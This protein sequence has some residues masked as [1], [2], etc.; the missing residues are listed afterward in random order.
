MH[1]AC[2]PAASA[3]GLPGAQLGSIF[4]Q[5]SSAA[6]QGTHAAAASSSSS[7]SSGDGGGVSA[8]RVMRVPSADRL[9]KWGGQDGCGVNPAAAAVNVHVAHLQVRRADCEWRAAAAGR[10]QWRGDP[11]G[12]SRGLSSGSTAAEPAMSEPAWQRLGGVVPKL[13]VVL[14]LQRPSKPSRPSFWSLRRLKRTMD[15]DRTVGD[16]PAVSEQG[17]RAASSLPRCLTY[18]K[19][20]LQASQRIA[21]G[22]SCQMPP[23]PPGMEPPRQ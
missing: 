3:S 12:N 5:V 2:M 7:G 21:T 6:L 16:P 13:P 17:G 22:R 4:R 1:V 9:Q 8:A 10:W 11:R 15:V 23:L 19:R 20:W 18:T 14:A